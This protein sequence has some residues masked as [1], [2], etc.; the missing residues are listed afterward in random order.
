MESAKLYLFPFHCGFVDGSNSTAARPCCVLEYR[1]VLRKRRRSLLILGRCIKG[2]SQM[3][4]SISTDERTARP[5]SRSA[6]TIQQ[7]R[8]Y[9]KNGVINLKHNTHLRPTTLL[10][11]DTILISS[12]FSHLF[13]PPH[14]HQTRPLT[15]GH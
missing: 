10:S 4:T 9:V 7:I 15:I 11:L 1:R 12:L 6:S 5:G 3:K 13:L 14:E 2:C 8:K